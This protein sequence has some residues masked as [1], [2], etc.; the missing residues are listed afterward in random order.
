VKNRATISLV[1]FGLLV[2]GAPLIGGQDK[3]PEAMINEAVSALMTPSASRDAVMSALLEVL[4]ASLLILSETEYAEEY[5]SRIEVAKT[6]LDRRGFFSDKA[7]QY[8]GLAYRLVTGGK[9]W[10][11]PEELSSAYREKDIMTQ[12]RKIC[13][14]LADSALSELAAGRNERSVRHLL[15][16]V[17]LVITPVQA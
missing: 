2:S 7:R 11:I 1:L 16:F 15:E 9:V 3:S 13:R 12:A 6:T 5:R 14:K 8:L 4:D 17:L 10:T